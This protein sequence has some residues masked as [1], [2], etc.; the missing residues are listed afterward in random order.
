MALVIGLLLGGLVGRSAAVSG[1]PPSAA[2][3]VLVVLPFT[4]SV[5]PPT[6]RAIHEVRSSVVIDAA[7]EAVWPHVVAFREL[8]PPTD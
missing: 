1:G 3:F 6:G 4:G 8:P 7:P 5:E 2:M